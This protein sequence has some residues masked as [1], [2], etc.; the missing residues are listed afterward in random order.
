[1][2]LLL[3]GLTKTLT[4]GYAAGALGLR[5]ALEAFR[6]NP[7]RTPSKTP[8]RRWLWL[9]CRNAVAILDDELLYVLAGRDVQLA[10]EA[11]ALATLPAALNF[12][13]LTS[14]LM[15]E[16]ARAGEL[17]TEATAI[18]QA[19]GGVPLRHA[20]I[21]LS[22]WRG[23]QAETTALNAI[24]A[25]E[26]PTPT[27]ARRSPW[28]STRWQCSTTGWATIRSRR[29]PRHGRASPTN[30]RSAAGPTRAHRGCC[31]R[32]RAGTSGARAGAAQLPGVC[33]RTSWALGLAARSRA[34]TS[35]GP[36]A[37]EQYRE[38]IERLAKSR[39]AGYLA[40]AHLVYGEWL[41]REGR[42]QDARE[43]TPHRPPTAVGDGHGGVR[44]AGRP[45]VA[46]HR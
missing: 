33:L 23:D 46:R 12:L 22:A 32:R 1:M 10:R 16:L 2:D 44:R 8:E 31:P 36:A 24:I 41:R 7:P 17:A 20:R 6:D 37:E 26:A 27:R 30:C 29:T 5:H 28:P 21:M 19:T 9:A 13:S 42:R 3:D 38:A 45:R 43:Q 18:T 34:L 25:K 39:M 11:G 40:R 14:V 15:G 4:S 35:T